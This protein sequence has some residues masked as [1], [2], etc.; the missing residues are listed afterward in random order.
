FWG[1][2]V[3]DIR[4]FAVADQ[5]TIEE[6]GAVE[7][8]PAR[9]LLIDDTVAAKADDLARKFPSNPTLSSLLA[10]ISEK[11]PADGMEAIIPAL[12]DKT[13][14]VLPELMPAGSVVLVTNPE[15]VRTRI[16]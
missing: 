14:S 11:Q 5:R 9:Q 12:T 7:L 2:E 3:T 13:Y 4:S 8:F 16:A 10:R 15:K 6:V 1:D